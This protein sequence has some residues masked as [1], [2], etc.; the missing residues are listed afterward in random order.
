[1]PGDNG[2]IIPGERYVNLVWY[3]NC[4]AD[5]DE[6]AS[7][8]TDTDG[9]RHLRTVPFSKV[10]PEVW[11]KHLSDHSRNFAL[12]IKEVLDK[13]DSPFVTAISDCISPQ[14]SFYNSKL[15][16]VG[17]A[18]AL[19]RPNVAQSTNQAALH[20]LLLEKLLQG[21]ITLSAYEQ[22]VLSY[23]HTTLLWGREVGAQY[24]SSSI[25]HLYHKTR[26]QLARKAQ[27]FGVRL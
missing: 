8:M 2:N 24:L 5:S 14:A 3:Y 15:F 13:I 4:S 25:G 27:R 6:F 7:I 20:C 1:M 26:H 21:K 19:F 10:Q 12:P 9:I 23:A 16:L 11:A 18:L 22:Q 17:D